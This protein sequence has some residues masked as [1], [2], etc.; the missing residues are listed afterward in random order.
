M[1]IVKAASTGAQGP[2]DNVISLDE[3]LQRA[4]QK[5]AAGDRIRKIEAVRKIFRCTHCANKCEK[6]GTLI[7]S[8][9]RFEGSS[10]RV[11]YAFCSSCAEE[12][13]DY[14][15]QLK[16]NGNQ[17]HYWH[18]SAWQHLWQ[19]WIEYQSA[20]DQYLKTKEFGQLLSEL[21]TDQH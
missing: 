6:C 12:Y 2:M 3:K 19:A 20:V 15:E 18:N 21:R 10:L 17:D 8:E 11:P 14:I 4:K 7:D 16:G 1:G 5:K 9:N 13:L